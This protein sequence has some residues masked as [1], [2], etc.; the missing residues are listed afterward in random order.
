MENVIYAVAAAFSLIGG[1]VV[2]C[3]F[4]WA[5]RKDGEEDRA[6]REKLGLRRKGRLGL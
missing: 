6:V 3:A 4:I 1:V 2:F 5:A